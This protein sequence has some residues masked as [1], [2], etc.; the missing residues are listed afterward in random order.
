LGYT[1][2]AKLAE[3]WTATPNI[4]VDEA[5]HAAFDLLPGALQ[6]RTDVLGLF[7]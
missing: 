6:G 7:D 3:P 5:D 4:D 1:R 2:Y